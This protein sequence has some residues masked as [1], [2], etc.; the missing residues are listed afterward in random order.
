MQRNEFL[1]TVHPTCAF[2]NC[3]AA[4]KTAKSLTLPWT[5]LPRLGVFE[6]ISWRTFFLLG[7]II[8]SIM[9]NNQEDAL[10]VPRSCVGRS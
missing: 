5:A 3:R 9:K 10:R 2:L 1:G 6:L 4:G 8:A 7:V